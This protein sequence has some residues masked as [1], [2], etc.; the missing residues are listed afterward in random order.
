MRQRCHIGNAEN[1]KTDCVQCAY[2]RLSAGT[3]TSDLH[4]HALDTV[5]LCSFRRLSCRNLCGERRTFTRT[6]ESRSTGTRPAQG[7]AFGVGNGNN[8]IVER[9]VDVGYRLGH[10]FLYFLTCS[11]FSLCFCHRVVLLFHLSSGTFAGT[12]I[13]FGALTAYRQSSSV[14]YASIAS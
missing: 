9:R 4:R 5:L 1:T 8:R 10:F 11:G 7:A 2:S 6:F 14:S 13:G 3:G 12:R